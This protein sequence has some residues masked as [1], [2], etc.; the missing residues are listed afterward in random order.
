MMNLT[1]ANLAAVVEAVIASPDPRRTLVVH[2]DTRPALEATLAADTLTRQ[3][4]RVVENVL[5]EPGSVYVFPVKGGPRA[6]AAS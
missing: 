4:F 1:A 2:P 5:A 6:R 3:R